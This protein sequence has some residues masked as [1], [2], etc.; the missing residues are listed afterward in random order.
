MKIC[1]RA[2]ATRPVWDV[3][4][5]AGFSPPAR[6]CDEGACFFLDLFLNRINPGI[7]RILESI[8]SQRGAIPQTGTKD[9]KLKDAGQTFEWKSGAEG[10]KDKAKRERERERGK[11][12][13]KPALSCPSSPLCHKGLEKSAACG[14]SKSSD[15]AQLV[16]FVCTKGRHLDWDYHRARPPCLSKVQ[17]PARDAPPAKHLQ[18]WADSVNGALVAVFTETG[19]RRLC[20]P[21]KLTIHFSADLEIL[22]EDLENFQS[23]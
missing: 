21:L 10:Q 5:V 14:F 23:S 2:N 7:R 12:G 8:V 15:L 6:W 19:G 11:R 3:L 9:V 4:F 17:Q 1:R 22:S 13:R 20:S 16:V 18:L